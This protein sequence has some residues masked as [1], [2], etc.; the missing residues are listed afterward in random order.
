MYT[1]THT[2]VYVREKG[3]ADV[4]LLLHH[5]ERTYSVWS[6]NDSVQRRVAGADSNRKREWNS[7]GEWRWRERKRKR[8]RVRFRPN[9]SIARWPSSLSLLPLLT[10]SLTD[11]SHFLALLVYSPPS[12]ACYL[13]RS[14]YRWHLAD[15]SFSLPLFLSR[16]VVLYEFIGDL[17]AT[18]PRFYRVTIM[19]KWFR[20]S[21]KLQGK[22][23]FKTWEFYTTRGRYTHRYYYLCIYKLRIHK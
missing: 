9:A 22:E 11:P 2:S 13:C 17:V 8:K 6:R 21:L 23:S 18:H 1:Y 14:V 4:G 15:S 19:W 20:K 3:P 7:D 12:L 5:C 10:S 16:H